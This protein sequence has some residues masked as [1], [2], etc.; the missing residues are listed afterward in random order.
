M[1][2][3]K[4]LFGSSQ[5]EEFQKNLP[6]KKF[7]N[8]FLGFV[9]VFII[10]ILSVTLYFFLYDIQKLI[11]TKEQEFIVDGI[12]NGILV[13]ILA[14]ILFYNSPKQLI[15]Q[16]TSLD[17]PLILRHSFILC[18]ASFLMGFIAI[19]ITLSLNPNEVKSIMNPPQNYTTPIFNNYLLDLI[20]FA[21]FCAIV[22]LSEEILYR[23]GVFR[24]LRVK[25]KPIIALII[26]SLIFSAIHG[27]QSITQTII[28]FIF[29]FIIAFYF[30]YKNNLLVPI[31]VHFVNNFL[32]TGLIIISGTWIASKMLGIS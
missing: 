21:L 18:T 10:V 32:N 11:F 2:F 5:V 16:L 15:T 20:M 3:I 23:G 22:S 13:I 8:L 4:F 24:A 28:T 30:E 25:F 9:W 27:F 19:L 31:I 14:P 7:T 17:A 12:I 29:G 1:R 6:I 26:S